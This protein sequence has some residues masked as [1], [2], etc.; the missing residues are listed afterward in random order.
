MVVLIFL[1]GALLGVVVGVIVCIRYV[2]QEMTA[3][4]E[5]T[6]QLVQSR[7]ANV[8][9]SVDMALAAW[10]AEMHSHHLGRASRDATD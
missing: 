2:R 3:R 7:L 4:I 9:S 5:P 10:H 1:L 8:Q 6:M